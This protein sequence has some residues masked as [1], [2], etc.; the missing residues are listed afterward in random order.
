MFGPFTSQGDS[1]HKYPSEFTR[2]HGTIII[3]MVLNSKI[4]HQEQ[5]KYRLTHWKKSMT[6]QHLHSPDDALF[7]IVCKVVFQQYIIYIHVENGKRHSDH[8]I[9]RTLYFFNEQVF[10]N[11]K[12]TSSSYWNFRGG[13]SQIFNVLTLFR[14]YAEAQKSKIQAA[15]FYNPSS[16]SFILAE[17][18][19]RTNGALRLRPFVKGLPLPEI[20]Q[21]IRFDWNKRII[22]FTAA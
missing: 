1:C 2:L 16:I 8:A 17:C 14:N 18:Q 22:Y 11:C 21:I 12:Y 19:D 15:I 4:M 10:S 9:V 20:P 3:D 7:T 13:N 5:A 6:S